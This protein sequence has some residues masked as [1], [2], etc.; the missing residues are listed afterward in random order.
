[1]KTIQ[2]A[3][4]KIS[5]LS[6]L[7]GQKAQDCL[8]EKW[9][10]KL[11]IKPFQNGPYRKCLLTA[12]HGTLCSLVTG[13][14]SLPITGE[15]GQAC[16]CSSINCIRFHQPLYVA[17]VFIKQKVFMV[18]QRCH[19]PFSLGWQLY[20]IVQKPRLVKVLELFTMEAVSPKWTWSYWFPAHVLWDNKAMPL[21]KSFA[22]ALTLSFTALTSGTS[23]CHYSV[24]HPGHLCGGD[25]QSRGSG[26]KDKWRCPDW[27]VCRQTRYVPHFLKT[28]SATG[29][30]QQ[31]RSAKHTEE[32]WVTC[33]HHPDT[34]LTPKGFS[35]EL[36]MTWR[37]VSF[38]FL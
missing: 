28:A 13:A 26:T 16:K 35:D 1:V 2:L 7:I 37:S 12:V 25:S 6:D 9:G 23:H 18:T 20:W 8:T 14:T 38:W 21:K 3:L 36:M 30:Q 33:T 29:H 31:P 11:G 17:S 5:H 34:H 19:L 27:G 24:W 32:L 22:E 4:L 15:K 10:L